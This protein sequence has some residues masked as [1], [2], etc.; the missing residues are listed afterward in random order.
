MD[1]TVSAIITTH[2]RAP[3]IVLRAVKSILRQTYPQIEL[4]VVDDSG[5][6][7]H[8]RET[9]RCEVVSLCRDHGKT[10]KYISNEKCLGACAARNVGVDKSTGEFIAFLDDDDEWAAEKIEK[11][12]PL[13]DDER[14]ALAYSDCQRVCDESGKTVM[15]VERSIGRAGEVYPYLILSNF[16]G[17]TSI[18]LIRS[19][20][21]KDIGG[22]DELMRSAQDFDVWLRLAEKYRF[23]FLGEPL[24]IYHVHG[25]DR[26]SSDPQKRI[27]GLERINKKNAEYIKTHRRARWIRN[28]VIIPYYVAAGDKKKA[29]SVW[30]KCLFSQPFAVK[31]NL[32][33]L[34]R[35]LI[36][37]E[38]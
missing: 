28:L 29:W 10:V 31:Q 25:G 37:N 13:F 24:T 5:S 8:L 27:D 16:I 26:I 7:F 2:D 11:L 30:R 35:Y 38:Q 18:P 19:S 36:K 4:I 14:V 6:D 9:V 32:K 1:K 12:L 20:A 21:L 15:R 17:S 34:Y 33:Y 23:A 3:D 22:F